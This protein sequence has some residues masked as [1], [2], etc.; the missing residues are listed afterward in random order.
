MDAPYGCYRSGFGSRIFFTG[1]RINRTFACDV[2]RGTFNFNHDIFDNN[3]N[4][5]N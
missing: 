3:P 2:A 1:K 5:A 4:L